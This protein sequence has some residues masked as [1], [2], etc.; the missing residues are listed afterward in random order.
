MRRTLG[1]REDPR[2]GSLVEVPWRNRCGWMWVRLAKLALN[3]GN[4]TA[5]DLLN[6]RCSEWPDLQSWDFP[7]LGVQGWKR[8]MAGA[9]LI[10]SQVGCA[11]S[12]SESTVPWPSTV[13]WS[14]GWGAHSEAWLGH[15]GTCLAGRFS[16][17]IATTCYNYLQSNVISQ[18]IPG[19][20]MKCH[21]DVS[22]HMQLWFAAP[23][24]CVRRLWLKRCRRSRI[25]W[26]SW[27]TLTPGQMI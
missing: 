2:F 12:H 16:S 8:T 19:N 21:N 27:L 7:M 5:L 13:T 3:A 14:L 18:E 20:T 23:K 11:L 1:D 26:R 24:T 17:A 10:S 6:V 25:E 15:F 9:V 4:L 22:S